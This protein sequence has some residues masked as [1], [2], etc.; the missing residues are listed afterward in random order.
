[1]LTTFEFSK[2]NCY[3]LSFTYIVFCV[4]I[5]LYEWMY[6]VF[7]EIKIMCMSLLFS[8]KDLPGEGNR[9]ERGTGRRD[10]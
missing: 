4:L 7:C 9:T 3:Y 1:M 5:L 10:K 6:Q 2:L 8:G